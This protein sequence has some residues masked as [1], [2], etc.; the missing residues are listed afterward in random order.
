VC[1]C[2]YAR[3]VERLT[4]DVSLS[5]GDDKI[6]AVPP[7]PSCTCTHPTE[8]EHDGDNIIINILGVDERLVHD[9]GGTVTVSTKSSCSLS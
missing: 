6:P 4:S 5:L 8:T 2:V 1:V 7:L 3:V 9:G